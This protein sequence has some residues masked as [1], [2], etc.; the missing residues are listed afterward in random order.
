[1]SSDEG[2]NLWLTLVLLHNLACSGRCRLLTVKL[3]HGVQCQTSRL[4]MQCTAVAL[5]RGSVL[6][7]A[8]DVLQT[9]G[10]ECSDMACTD[11][12]AIHNNVPHL[13]KGT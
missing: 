1:M 9:N 7:S 8:R 10:Y 3:Q 2:S 11:A 5:G 12:P 4:C 13:R 6:F